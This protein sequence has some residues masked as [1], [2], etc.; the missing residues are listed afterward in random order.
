VGSGFD[1]PNGVVVDGS[2]NVF[3][4]DGGGVKKLDFSDPPSLSFVNTLVGSTSSDSP[5]TVT[6]A[7]DG[8]QPLTFSAVSYGTNFPEASGVATDCITSAPLASDTSCTLSI[9]FTPLSMGSIAGSVVLTDN[10]LNVSPST[11]QSIALSGTATGPPVTLAFGVA[12]PVGVAP[13]GNAGSAVTVEE[14]DLNGNVVPA[15][16]TITLTVTYPDTTTQTCT[17][18]AASGVA[19]F[20]LGGAALT[21]PGSYTYTATLAGLTG[22]VAFET[23]AQMA[24]TDPN[25]TVGTPSDTQTATL[26]LTTNSTLGSIALLTQGAP[27]LDFQAAAGGTRSVGTAYTVAQTCTVNYTFNPK[28]PGQRNGAIVLYDNASPTHAVAMVY[29]Q[30]TGNGP[31]VIFS[32]NNIQSVLGSGFF[33]PQG[34]TVDGAG[35]VFVADSG[36]NAVKEIVAAGGYTTVNTLGSGF[37]DPVSVALDGAANVFV[38]DQDNR[39]VKEI[40]AAGGYTIVN[41]LGSGWSFPDGV[42]VDGAGNVF[43]ADQGTGT[44]VEIVAAGGYTTVNTVGSG[45]ANPSGVALDGSGNVFVTDPGSSAVDQIPASCIAGA[46]N[47]SCMLNLGSGFE[48]PYGVA[49]DANDNVFVAD[50]GTNLV[51]EILAAGGYTTLQTL[52][53]GS[54]FP[55]GAAVDGSGNVF[56]ADTGNN[57]VKKLDYS[58][59][60]SLSFATTPAGTTSSDSP[61]TV[62]VANDG[63]QTLTFSAVS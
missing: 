42:A 37:N 30:R 1:N 51:S 12:P 33:S 60:P 61:Q 59:E 29:M 49:V 9:D 58:D 57:V 22:A 10:S 41:T 3:V 48:F 25:T 16:D 53:S 34:M 47:S 23:V 56:V 6:I 11:T 35:N 27:N 36:Q 39:A 31:Q 43:V 40:L 50:S 13:G 45:Y 52:G 46:N 2:G 19:G 15:A 24:Y 5:Q 26:V 63:N 20:N 4:S 18:T 8:N 7:N 28:H 54:N 44:V 21:E 55:Y 32:R 14:E 62:T 38:A 17:S